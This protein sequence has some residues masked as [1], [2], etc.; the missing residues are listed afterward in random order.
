MSIKN[1]FTNLTN[2]FRRSVS[3]KRTSKRKSN[4]VKKNRAANKADSTNN[5]RITL[6]IGKGLVFVVIIISIGLLYLVYQAYDFYTNLNFERFPTDKREEIFEWD[7][8]ERVN[9]ALIGMDKK[10]TGHLF[11]D[12]VVVLHIN[13]EAPKLGIFS[14]NTNFSVSY[15]G[16][17]SPIKSSYIESVTWENPLDAVISSNESL[18]GISIHKYIIINNEELIKLVSEIPMPSIDISED[19]VDQDFD[20]IPKGERNLEPQ[21]LYNYLATESDGEDL[22]MSRLVIFLRDVFRSG[23]SLSNL[24]YYKDRAKTIKEN[25]HTDMS[26]SELLKLF[27]FVRGLRD[28]QI[29][30]A[31]T[32]DEGAI[33]GGEFKDEWTPIVQSIDKDLKTI[34]QNQDVILEQARVEVLNASGIAGFAGRTGRLLENT[35]CRVVRVGNAVDPSEKNYIYV[36]NPKKFEET[37]NEVEAAFEGN[38]EVIKEEYP[39]RHVGDIVV[40]IGE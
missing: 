29:K 4:Y 18:L 20:I 25:I 26:T 39:H 6:P 3:K 8:K 19:I 13:P 30:V 35:G 37:L 11:A 33:K 24:I 1:K 17:K 16:Q 23:D 15:E 14:V 27:L 9:I 40:V 38:V 21:M 31:Y 34:F 28:D 10:P 5:K 7:G 2:R 36:E 22:K 32:R 12:R